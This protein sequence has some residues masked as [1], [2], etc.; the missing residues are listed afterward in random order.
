MNLSARQLV[1]DNIVS[2]V[3]ETIRDF[4][5]EPAWIT[6]EITEHRGRGRRD[7]SVDLRAVEGD[8]RQTRHR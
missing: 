6:L 8:R 1:D 3:A 2:E 4:A 7:E 5:I